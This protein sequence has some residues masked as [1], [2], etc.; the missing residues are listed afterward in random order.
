MELAV[1]AVVLVTTLALLAVG[2]AS[3]ATPAAYRA[4]VN[5][6]CRSYTPTG[7]KLEAAM[8]QAETKKDYRA[9]GVALGELL[10]LNLSQDRRI[11]AV[12]VP[13]PLKAQMRP[14]LARLKKIDAHTNLAL[15]R[16]R[17]GNSKGLAAELN[18]IAKLA[19]PLNAQLDKAGL[20][21]CGSNQS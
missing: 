13:R 14:I 8:K 20:R 7:K 10:I 4:Q 12:P 2:A 1:K 16:A 6:I 5:G 18:A 15:L 11:E 21:D 9:Y 3:A 19:K 17:Q